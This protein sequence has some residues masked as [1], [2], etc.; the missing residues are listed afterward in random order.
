MLG[1]SKS[2][3][4]QGFAAQNACNVHP[5]AAQKSRFVTDLR[6]FRRT[7]YLHLCRRHVSFEVAMFDLAAFRGFAA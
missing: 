4:R 1:R 2:A 7:R 3:L 5:H 6:P